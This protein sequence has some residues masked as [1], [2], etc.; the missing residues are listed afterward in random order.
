MERNEENTVS[1]GYISDVPTAISSNYPSE[2]SHE[3]KQV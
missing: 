1:D 3:F 2:I